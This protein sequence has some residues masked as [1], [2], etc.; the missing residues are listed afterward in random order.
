MKVLHLL[1]TGTFGGIECLLMNYTGISKHENVFVFG[2]GGGEIAERISS[3]G[4]KVYVLQKEKIGSAGLLRELNAVFCEERPQAVIVHQGAPLLWL[5]VCY[6]AKKYPSVKTFC[7]AHCNA[8]SL[9][10]DT[11]RG[12]WLR[13]LICRRAFRCCNRV[14][15]VSCSVRDSVA[16][17]ISIPK[18]RISVIYNGIDLSQFKP[19]TKNGDGGLKLIYVG[20]LIKDK[21]VQRILTS[22]AG[23]EN[24]KITL[25]IVGDGDYRDT[26]EQMARQLGLAHRVTFLGSR[27]DVPQLLASAD[28]FVHFPECEEGFGIAII[29]AMA[30]GLVCICGRSGAIPEII[31]NG[32]NG[33]LVEKGNVSMLAS[34]ITNVMDRLGSPELDSVRTE[35]LKT[36]EMFSAERFAQRLDRVAEG[37]YNE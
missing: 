26:L 3:D 30:S 35:A 19:H 2:W 31:T 34:Q 6:I 29:E 11:E 37:E 8:H 14:L 25:T 32:K 27:S 7:Y 9:V 22:L 24:D 15:A 5:F 1:T 20:R 12:L 18:D 23:T 4:N 16:E 17:F 28:A 21:G 10:R 36:A 33:F 13:R